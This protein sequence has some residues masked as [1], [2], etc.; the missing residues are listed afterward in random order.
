QP[1][2]GGSI[3]AE[4]A[5][6]QSGE[7]LQR[8]GS[9]GPLRRDLDLRA[10]PG[11]ERQKPHDRRAADTLTVAADR[12]LGVERRGALDEPRRGARM[13]PPPIGDGDLP[14]HRPGCGGHRQASPSRTSLA[15]LIYLRPASRATTAACLS[16]ASPRTLA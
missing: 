7:R 8:G 2:G 15:T 6:D 3:F 11:A 4:A 16:D 5:L 14:A 12:D 13:Q 10:G 9:V 1:A